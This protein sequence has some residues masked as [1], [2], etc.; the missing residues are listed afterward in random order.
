MFIKA[1]EK[2]NYPSR[3]AILQ[4]ELKDREAIAFIGYYEEI[5]DC[6]YLLNG[7]YELEAAYNISLPVILLN[8]AMDDKLHH[9]E[10]AFDDMLIT[11]K[12]KKV[13][14]NRGYAK[15]A[16]ILEAIP[17]FSGKEYLDE[18]F[19]KVDIASY[20]EFKERNK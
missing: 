17:S 6:F 8:C 1:Y 19:P 2:I 14:N 5:D 12:G 15:F 9:S 13:F 16:D 11:Y 10:I 4:H 18:D 3:V 7:S 20:A